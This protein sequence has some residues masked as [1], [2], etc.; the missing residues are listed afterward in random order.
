MKEKINEFYIVVWF[1]SRVLV[2]IW[3]VAPGADLGTCEQ[4]DIPLANGYPT[5][6]DV[7]I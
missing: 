7:V 5:L 6:I 2:Y 1:N 4:A 3:C